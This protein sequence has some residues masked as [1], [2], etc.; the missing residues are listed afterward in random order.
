[1][2]SD[3]QPGGDHV[4]QRGGVTEGGELDQPRPVGKL[5]DQLGGD[6]E[7]QAGLADPA[8]PGQ[9]DQTMGSHLGDQFL[10]GAGTTHKTGA[11]DGQVPRHRV[12]GPQGRELDSQALGADLEDPVHPREVAQGM[13]AQIDQNDVVGHQ[14]RR[15]RRD[16]DLAAVPGR[17]HPGRPVQRRT[18]VVLSPQLGRAGP[19]PHPRRQPQP[20][21]PLDRRQHGLRS[22]RERR[23]HPV[24]SVLEH[25]TPRPFHRGVQHLVMSG[26]R[27]PHRLGIGLPQAGRPLDVRKQ[28]CHRARR[29]LPHKPTSRSLST[30]PQSDPSGGQHVDSQPASPRQHETIEI[31]TSFPTLLSRRYPGSVG[32]TRTAGLEPVSKSP[33]PTTV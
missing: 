10:Y 4:G 15:G 18:E 13:P 11:L 3:S 22:R 20:A 8:N 6:L 9:G 17:H 31:A 7:G 21:L 16:Q 12:Q 30:I 28:K 1:M 33:S 2:G 19:D 14:L 27:R 32:E 23:A 26:Q 5:R 29:T 25:P 24:P